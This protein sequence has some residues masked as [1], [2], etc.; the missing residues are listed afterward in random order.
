MFYDIAVEDPDRV[1]VIDPAGRP[2]SFGQLFARA[3]RLTHALRGL[4][5]GVGDGVV[6]VVRNGFAYYEML[7]ATM[8]MGVYFTPVNYRSTPAE[9]AYIVENSGARVVVADADIAV[10]CT[11]VLDELGIT[12]QRRFSIGPVE[13]WSDFESWGADQPSGAPADRTAGQTMLYTSG[14]T[15]RPKGVRRP[16]SGQPPA[17]HPDGIQTLRAFG[18]RPGAGVH[19][20]ACPLYHAAPGT[21][22]MGALHLGHTLVLMDRFDAQR[23][24]GLIEQYRVTSTHLVPTMFHRMLR[25]PERVRS[26][27]DLSSLSSV[28][29]GAAPCPPQVKQEMIDWLG[30]V[31]VEYYGASEGMVSIVPTAEW[32]KAPGTVGRPLP[33]VQVRVL[34]DDGAELPP[35]EPGIL[36]FHSA[37]TQLDYHGDAEKTAAARRGEL[38]TVGDVG[39]LDEEGRIFLCDRRTDLILSGGVNIY[40]AEIEGRLLAHPEVADAAVIGEPD[41][42]WGQRVVAFV[43]PVPESVGDESLARRL[44]DHCRAALAGFKIPNRF[45]F[46]DELPRTETGKMLRR[47]LRA[48]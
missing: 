16:L 20:V 45:E 22:S 1:A 3:N 38:F 29:H 30:P 31:V 2:V 24:L 8:Q 39:Y 44:T 6:V 43:Q 7:L 47:A 48:R 9:I 17:L 4:G 10:T 25:L 11:W 40:P 15:G 21:F 46:R 37:S 36:Y 32:L 23:T 5:A 12:E 27:H 33:S 26:G 13:G 41:P 35:G 18:L 28:M 19:L 42:E 34:D 14:T